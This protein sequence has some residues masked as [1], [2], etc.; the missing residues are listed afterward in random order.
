M[1]IYSR[2][3]VCSFRFSRAAWGLFSN[4]YPLAVPIAAGPWTCTTSEAIYQAAK[5][6]AHSEVQRRIAAASTP[7]A[8]AAIGRTPG[9]GIAPDWNAQRVD[10]MRWVLRRKREANPH[11]IDTLLTATGDRPIVELSTR[12]PW[13][14]G[15]ARRRSLRGQ[16]RPRP[17][18]DGASPTASRRRSGGPLRRLARPHPRRPFGRPPRCSARRPRGR[19]TAVPG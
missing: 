1:R 18:V 10:V 16:Q 17:V 14:G 11:E 9:L 7:R 4:F 8:A 19:L 12:D 2:D 15:A 5:F 3:L 13:W 6:P